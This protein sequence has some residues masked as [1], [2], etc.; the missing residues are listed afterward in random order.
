ML[1][2]CNLNFHGWLRA[3][4]ATRGMRVKERSGERLIGTL[5]NIKIFEQFGCMAFKERLMS[6]K[7]PRQPIPNALQTFPDYLAFEAQK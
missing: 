3:C 6:R 7:A 4:G 2:N 5:H 1:R